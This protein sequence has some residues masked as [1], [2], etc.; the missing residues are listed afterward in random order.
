V[1]ARFDHAGEVHGTKWGCFRYPAYTVEGKVGMEASPATVL[2]AF[3]PGATP[4]DV[5][6]LDFIPTANHYRFRT[7]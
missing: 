1:R 7:P 5:C 2:G 6:T 4:R 3:L